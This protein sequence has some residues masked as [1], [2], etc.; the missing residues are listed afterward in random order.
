MFYGWIIVGVTFLIYFFNVGLM[1][2]GA[3]AINAKMIKDL[4][5]LF[6]PAVVGTAVAISTACQGILSAASGALA[7]KTGVKKLLIFGSL[8][9]CAGALAISFGPENRVYF[10]VVYGS[11]MGL[12]LAFGGILSSQ[13]LLND[14]FS[15]KKGFAMSIAV[16]SGSVC[17]MIAPTVMSKLTDGSW[18]NGWFLVAAMTAVSAL[19]AAIIVVNRP[20]D[21]GLY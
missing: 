16:S 13:T 6:N 15:K 7:R 2:Y 5:P 18:K 1:L 17:G 21:K 3:P 20:E 4:D 14:W 8:M 11:M 12:G 19:L 9:L 10:I